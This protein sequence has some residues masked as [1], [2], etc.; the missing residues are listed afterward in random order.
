MSFPVELENM[1]FSLEDRREIIKKIREEKNILFQ[2]AKSALTIDL[3]SSV[4]EGLEEHASVIFEAPLTQSDENRRFENKPP[5][6]KLIVKRRTETSPNETYTSSRDQYFRPQ[7][8]QNI[9]SRK[10]SLPCY[11]C[12][13]SFSCKSKLKRHLQSHQSVRNWRCVYCSKSYKSLTSLKEHALHSYGRTF[14]G[15]ND[16][17]HRKLFG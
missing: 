5:K 10:K 15:S 16:V 14:E 12:R 11:I 2:I 9:T 6:P 13:K 4:Y 7:H 8:L 3:D 1:T 17:R